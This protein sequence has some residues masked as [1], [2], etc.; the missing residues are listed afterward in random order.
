MELL[1]RYIDE[2]GQDL[3]LDDFNLKEAQMRLPARKHYWVARLI[4]AKIKRNQL[5]TE[6]NKLKKDVVKK[7]IAESPIKITPQTAEHAADNHDTIVTITEKIKELDMIVEYLE[8][9][10]KIMSQMGYE[11]KNIVEIQKLEQL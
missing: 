5:Q 9:V 2:I 8:K 3:V 7:V 6:R 4:D 10:E 1:K 11:I